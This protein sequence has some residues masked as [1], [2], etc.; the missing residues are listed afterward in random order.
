MKCE[1]CRDFD[2]QTIRLMRDLFSRD[3]IVDLTTTIVSKIKYFHEQFQKLPFSDP[4]KMQARVQGDFNRTML[5]K[6][7]L[8][9]DK[10]SLKAIQKQFKVDFNIEHESC[11]H[12]KVDQ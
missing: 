9:I 1:A 3:E 10:E 11:P 2:R 8:V 5:G 12:P 7:I 6:F 4:K